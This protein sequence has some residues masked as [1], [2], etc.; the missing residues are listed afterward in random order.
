MAD[1]DKFDLAGYLGM[2]LFIGWFFGF[3]LS[4][5]DWLYGGVG[6]AVLAVVAMAYLFTLGKTG[7][8]AAA[9]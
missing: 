6:A 3:V 4:R 7:R 5:G 8:P 2:G 1:I 9:A